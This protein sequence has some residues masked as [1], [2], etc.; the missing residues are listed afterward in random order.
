MTGVITSGRYLRPQETEPVRTRS[1][2]L[3]LLSEACEL[4]H[5]LACSY[6]FTA[7]TI[8]NE[9]SEGIT[10][11]QLQLCRK[12]AGQIFFVAAEEMLHLSLAWNMLSAIGG[13]PYYFRPNFPQS[14]KYYPIHLSLKLERFGESAM[15]RFVFY[16]RP[17]ALSEEELAKLL[18]MPASHL[19]RAHSETVGELYARIA[20]GF[21]AIPERELF[22][23]N[24]ARQVSNSLLDF[25]SLIE[26]RNR[27]SALRAIEEITEQ[28]E[29]TGPDREDCHFGL[30]RSVLE[31]LGEEDRR[32]RIQKV[33]FAP[34]RPAIANPM[35][36][37]RGDYAARGEVIEDPTAQ[38][39]SELFD[40][41]YSLMLRMLS[42]VFAA[43]N[44][45]V[46]IVASF[47]AGALRLMTTVLKPLGEGLTMMPAGPSYPGQNAGPTFGLTRHVTL[48]SEGAAAKQIALEEIGD[49]LHKMRELLATHAAEPVIE[50]VQGNLDRVRDFLAAPG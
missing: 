24:P 6:L 11:Q 15:R 17:S 22:I 16:E 26:V 48:P 33:P 35:T 41:L 42:F 3:S 4:E 12:W 9:I 10:W 23:G 30:F 43:D 39:V 1:E 25:P 28:G 5:G 7:F 49:V 45:S 27:E 36:R 2:L 29:G 19:E 31:A 32:S 46:P 47:A 14:A 21:A 8:K 44:K 34:A 20:S 50:R 18:G 38:Q 37:V 40:Q 13:M